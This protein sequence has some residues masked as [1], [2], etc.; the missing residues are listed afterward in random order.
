[1]YYRSTATG[2]IMSES[3]ARILDDIFGDNTVAS[4][5]LDG[6]LVSVENPSVINCICS[7]NMASAVTRYREIHGCSVADAKKAVY[8][9]RVDVSKAQNIYKKKRKKAEKLDETA[10]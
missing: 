4:M 8:S 5:M 9:M 6:L 7:G 1:M 10:K 3:S 2:K